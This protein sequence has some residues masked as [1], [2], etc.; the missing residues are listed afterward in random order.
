[1]VHDIAI[2]LRTL[3]MLLSLL[4]IAR[5]LGRRTLSELTFY[6]FV[7]G[8]FIGNIGSSVITDEEF[9]IRNGLIVL[10]VATLWILAISML[11]LKSVPARKLIEAEPLTVLRRGKILENNLKK[12][13]YNVNDLLEMLREQGIFDPNE[14]EMAL[15]ESDGH[16][17]VLKKPEYQ[18]PSAK[19]FAIQKQNLTPASTL[20][21]TEVIINGKIIDQGLV[22]SGL[23]LDQLECQLSKA[24]VTDWQEVTLAM[25]TPDGQ[26]YV[27]KRNDT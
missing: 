3:L 25:V 21:G 7:I 11:A 13:Y 1:M 17:S 15:I 4:L 18:S 14:V 19:D 22:Q 20:A 27:D 9:G 8:L 24:G 10:T 6:D 23:T 5:I 2:I 16:L 12:R 26:L